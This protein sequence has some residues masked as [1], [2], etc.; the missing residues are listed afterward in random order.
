MAGLSSFVWILVGGLLM[1]LVAMV[2]AITLLLPPRRLQQLL[3][4]LVSLAAGSLLGGALFH[5][6]PEGMA[7]MEPHRGGFCIA[8]GFTAFL[9]LEQFL[10][11]HHSH[12]EAARPRA[13]VAVLILLGDALHNFIGGLGIASTFLM[14]PAAGVAAWFAAVAHEVPQELGDFAILVHSGWKPRTALRWNVISAL[15]FPLGAVLAW[16][17]SRSV[18]VAE[19]VLFASGNFLY[20]AASDLVPEIKAGSSLRS[21]V[22]SFCWFSAGLLLMLVLAR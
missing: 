8:A 9:A 17:I 16:F 6:L 21:A 10:H 7:A 18:S 4:P 13:P 2:G 19:L 15:T 3:V 11:W 12:R 1:A 14:N 20:I 5:M 22:L